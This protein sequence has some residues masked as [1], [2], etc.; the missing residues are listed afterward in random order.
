MTVTATSIDGE[1]C[2]NIRLVF[3]KYMVVGSSKL[4][5]LHNVDRVAR[6]AMYFLLGVLLN[7]HQYERASPLYGKGGGIDMYIA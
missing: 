4:Q 7:K 5:D 3:W 1:V 2:L 6:R